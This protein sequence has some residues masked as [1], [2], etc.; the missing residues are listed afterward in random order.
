M[1]G[2]TDGW[3]VGW[4][5]GCSD[6]SMNEWDGCIDVWMDD[7]RG[8]I[9]WESMGGWKGEWMDLVGCMDERDGR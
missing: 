9:G 5:D 2:R 4:V 7:R 6:G 8:G 1:D 3:M